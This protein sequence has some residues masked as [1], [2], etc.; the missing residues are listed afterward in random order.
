MLQEEN[1]HALYKLIEA[2]VY[3]Q[4]FYSD[5]NCNLTVSL[6][7]NSLITFNSVFTLVNTLSNNYMFAGFSKLIKK[8]RRRFPIHE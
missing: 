5:I 3:M 4:A 7:F 1:L 8:L 2:G 6:R